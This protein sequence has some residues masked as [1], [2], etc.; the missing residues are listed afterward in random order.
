[1]ADQHATEPVHAPSRRLWVLPSWLL[2]QVASRANRL[3]AESFGR[4]GVRLHYAVLAGLAEFGPVSQAELSRR[5]GVDRS[6]LVAALNELER[7][8]FAQRAPDDRDRRR[9][10]LRITPA[11]QAELRLLDARVQAAAAELLAPLAPR[12]QEQLVSLLQRVLAH[13]SEG[14]RQDDARARASCSSSSPPATRPPR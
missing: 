6:D 8:D 9:N 2:N 1:V 13:H 7:E 3:V 11:G 4:P 14:G 12:E 10:A 5:L